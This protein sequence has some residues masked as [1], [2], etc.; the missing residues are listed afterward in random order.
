MEMLYA[1]P[2]IIIF[3][4]CCNISIVK[5]YIYLSI[6]STMQGRGTSNYASHKPSHE[7]TTSTTQFDD[8]LMKRGIVTMEQVMMAKGAT[9][10]EAQRLA[11]EKKNEGK[12]TT[13]PIYD[14]S[15]KGNRLNDD[16]DDTDTDDD[17]DDEDYLL[18]DDELFSRYRQERMAQ[19]DTADANNTSMSS[20]VPKRITRDEWTTHVN[21]ASS[22]KWVLVVLWDDTTMR[23]QDIM[24]DLSRILQEYSSWISIVTI[25]YQ[26]ANPHWPST[27]VPAVFAYRNGTKQH[28]FVTQEQGK[29]PT[30]EQLIHLLNE[31]S[32]L[33]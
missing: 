21:E 24:Q 29:F 28:E 31:W 27:R 2:L 16:D 6:Y 25:P 15:S 13:L 5:T 3:F 10:E 32:I 4:P 1:L 9:P 20:T 7:L 26:E 33:S 8:E 12:S 11:E 14:V 22:D 19:L 23:T 18:E 30:P 17:D